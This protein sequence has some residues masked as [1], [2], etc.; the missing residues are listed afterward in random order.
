[1][2]N[3]Q[4]SSQNIAKGKISPLLAGPSALSKG[5]ICLMAAELKAK[6]SLHSFSLPSFTWFLSLLIAIE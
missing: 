3:T 1:M 5:L 2:Y 4:I 6:R